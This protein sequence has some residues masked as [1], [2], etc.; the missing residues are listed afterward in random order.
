[1]YFELRLTTREYE[2]NDGSINRCLGRRLGLNP[3][4]QLCVCKP[5]G[6]GASRNQDSK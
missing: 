1:M 5:P 6:A 4:L 3:E 2:A